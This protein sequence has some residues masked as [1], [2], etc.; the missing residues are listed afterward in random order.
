MY[1][2]LSGPFTIATSLPRLSS[3]PRTERSATAIPDALSI[4]VP[5]RAWVAG[6]MS[7][8]NGSRRPLGSYEYESE[9]VVASV[10]DSLAAGAAF[11]SLAAAGGT[12]GAGGGAVFADTGAGDDALV[13]CALRIAV[14]HAVRATRLIDRRT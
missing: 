3:T 9:G 11:F 14:A 2:L 7:V 8:R 13:C 6:P 12:I 4:F 10:F 1:V 5:L